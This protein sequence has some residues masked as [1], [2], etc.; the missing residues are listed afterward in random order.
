MKTAT[1]TINRG[2]GLTTTTKGQIT[3]ET[4][5]GVYIKSFDSDK[6][7]QFGPEWFPFSSENVRTVVH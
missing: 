1:I 7:E 2:K 4:T 3:G 5:H 6:E